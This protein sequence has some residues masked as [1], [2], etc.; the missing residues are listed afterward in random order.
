MD[1]NFWVKEHKNLNEKFTK[2]VNSTSGL[3]KQKNDSMN[4][5]I[6]HL[7]LPNHKSKKTN[8]IKKS[9][10]SIKYLN[11]TRK[12]KICIMRVSKGEVN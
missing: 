5:K 7:K 8:G 4:S 11:E 3:M 9:K 2:G 12:T 10:E 1:I 6:G